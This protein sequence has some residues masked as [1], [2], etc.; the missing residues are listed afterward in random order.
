MNHEPL[1][2]AHDEGHTDACFSSDGSKFITCGADGDVRIWSTQEGTDPSHNCIGE[3]SLSVR[4]KNGNLYL[5]TSDNDVQILTFP[6][7]ERNGILDRF[8]APINQISLSRDSEHIAL[9]GEDMEAKLFDL[10]QSGNEGQIFDG[11]SGPCLSVAVTSRFLAASSGDGKLR[12]WDVGSKTLKTEIECFPKVNSFAN[13]ELLC[14]IDFSPDG[15][16]LAYPDKDTVVVLNTSDWSQS[17]TLNS[18]DVSNHYS[19]VQW[20][21]CGQY[22]AATTTKGDIVIFHV[23]IRGV[24]KVS[25]HPNSTSICGLMW[26]PSGNGQIVYTDVEGQLGLASGCTEVK[27]TDDDVFTEH[28]LDFGDIQIESDDD[29]NENAISVEKLKKEVMG[30]PEPE[31]NFEE[32]S[33]APTPRPRT[34]EMPLQPSFMPSSTPEHLNPRYLCWNDVAIIRSYGCLA[35]EDS[36][37]SIEIEFH[38]STFH[39]SMMLQ[40]YQDYTM[41]CVSTAVVAVANAKQLTVIPLSASSKE[42]VLKIDDSLEEITLITASE[43][44]VCLATNNYLVRICSVFGI[45]RGVLSIPGPPVSLSSHQDSLLVSYHSAPVRKSDQCINTK[46]IKF[47]GL[48]MESRDINAALG[49]ESTLLW[50]GFTDLGTPAMMDSLGMISLHPT[51]QNIWVPFCDT[52]RHLK[53]PSDGFFVTAIMESCQTIFGIKCRGSIYPGFT[54][55]PTICELVLEPP[56]AEPETDK[57]QL[58][59]NLFAWSNLEVRDLGKKF[60]ESGLKAFALACKN[61]LDQRAVELMEILANPQLVSLATKYALKMNKRLIGEKLMELGSRLV[62]EAEDT[63]FVIG[64]ATTPSVTRKFIL[65]S[66]KTPRNREI[67]ETI[68]PATPDD[69]HVSESSINITNTTI[70]ESFSEEP[71]NPFS[72]NSKNEE[73]SSNPLSLVNKYAGVD[74]ESKENK[75]KNSDNEKRKQ[76]DSTETE[77]RK[78]KQRKLDRFMFSKR[79]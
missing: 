32:S 2:Y 11:L 34:P 38:N 61:G 77:E 39:N 49:P 43:K 4:E 16:A 1:R 69:S 9:A 55:K 72:K 24:R 5:A 14:R 48:T 58:E 47:S 66:K 22:L 30:E 8:V 50:L 52:T 67:N 65:S 35:D 19:I 74:Y 17:S 60:N 27:S 10:A 76:P 41:G 68:V 45:Q 54:P 20:S 53:S 28:A 31:L 70:N 37:K 73:T 75:A 79:V 78:G 6:G 26:N 42:W 59:M 44:L 12:V 36:G 21:P 3:W 29:D 46:L 51:N 62:G 56:F 71:K 15:S 13:A 25:K 57:T 23:S 40:N 63:S 33:A 18:T 64:A 7:G